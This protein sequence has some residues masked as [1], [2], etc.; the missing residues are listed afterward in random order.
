MPVCDSLEILHLDAMSL[1][2]SGLVG[3]AR[4]PKLRVLRLRTGTRFD[5]SS[6]PYLPTLQELAIEGLQARPW[7][8]DRLA[9]LLP[10]LVGLELG[11]AAT[12]RRLSAIPWLPVELESAAV[13]LAGPAPGEL[14]AL[15]AHV[16]RLRH[17]ARP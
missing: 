9:E 10:A 14:D 2:G 7:G 17:A 8:F 4:F 11:A 1:D 6:L 13:H 15:F 12:A 5:L 16:Q 3:L